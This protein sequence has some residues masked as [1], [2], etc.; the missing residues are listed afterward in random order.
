M[1]RRC[2][3]QQLK[4]SERA[5]ELM[6]KARALW[7]GRT[8]PCVRRCLGEIVPL[9][10]RNIVRPPLFED[11]LAEDPMRLPSVVPSR[12]ELERCA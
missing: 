8:A 5:H 3:L 10:E 2:P 7:V 6:P 12:S 4:E 11:R 1:F 9:G